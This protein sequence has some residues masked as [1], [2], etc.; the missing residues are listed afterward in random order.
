MDVNYF[1]IVVVL[2]LLY[3]VYHGYV[4][5]LIISLA[6]LTGMILGVY[7]GL[8]FS[9]LAANWLK[10]QW[11]IEVPILSFAITFLAILIVVYLIGKLLEKFVNILSLG[12][13]NKIGG[14]VFN[15]CKMFLII[16]V[17]LFITEQTNSKFAFFD[18]SYIQEGIFY[19][20]LKQVEAIVFPLVTS[21]NN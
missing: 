5:G 6:T 10:N 17:L 7:G 8:T 21:F 20:Y 4:K 11:D 9:D 13:F 14:I 2:F 3:A 18:F 19:S 15:L 16:A 12:I 1:D